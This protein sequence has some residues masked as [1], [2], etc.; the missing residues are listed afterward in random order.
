MLSL[1]PQLLWLAPYSSTLLRLGIGISFFYAGYLVMVRR[2]EFAKIRIPVIGNPAIWMLW[3][4]GLVTAV[5]GF[6]IF[7]GFGTQLAAMIGLLIALKHAL[8][9]RRFD[10]LRPLPRST[11]LLLI[12][13]C[14]A[15]VVSGAG[16]LGFDLQL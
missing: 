10:A 11:S 14:L 8:L 6:A 4:S 1:F 5:D 2:E 3:I 13:M 7:I 12:L 9:P 16:H 15:L